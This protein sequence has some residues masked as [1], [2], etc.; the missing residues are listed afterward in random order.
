[1][2]EDVNTASISW[3]QNQHHS[4]VRIFSMVGTHVL[5][6]KN[7]DEASIQIDK[8]S[9]SGSNI[10]QLLYETTGWL[11]PIQQIEYWILGLD[12]DAP[13][14]THNTLGLVETL[15]F[16]QWHMHFQKYQTFHNM[17]MPKKIT[18]T[19]PDITIKFSIHR[20]TLNPHQTSR[21]Q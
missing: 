17:M 15:Q 21:P 14:S 6:Q 19:H 10:E 11:I 16:G 20:W 12:H 18:L 9:Y 13:A 1:M 4:E 3:K 5:L 2:P 7:N 8:K